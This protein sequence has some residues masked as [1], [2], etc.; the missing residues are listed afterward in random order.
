MAREVLDHAGLTRYF[1]EI[2]GASDDEELSTKAD[3][4]AEALR[5][6]QASRA[7]TPPTP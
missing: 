1:T 6:L 4:V 2:A 5:G 7:S 3:V